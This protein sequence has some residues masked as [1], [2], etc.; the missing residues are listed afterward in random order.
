[1]K[2]TRQLFDAFVRCKFKLH[3]LATGHEGVTPEYGMLLEDLDQ[4]FREKAILVFQQQFD[5]KQI[6]TDS[7][8][9][10]DAQTVGPELQ[11]SGGTYPF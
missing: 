5:A 3:L 2:I 11:Q 9:I 1:L 7:A 6:I 4:E 8:S 10:V